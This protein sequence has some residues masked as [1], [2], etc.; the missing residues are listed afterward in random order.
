[1]IIKEF[2]VILPL[3]VDEYRIGQLYTVAEASKNQTGGGEGVE[4]VVNE[5]FNERSHPLVGNSTY[6]TGQYTLK[7]YHLE[8]KI[9]GFVRAVMPKGS[10]VLQEDAWNAFPYCKTV[11]TNPGYMKENM[12]I[13]IETM[14]KNDN[15]TT[16]NI[17]RLPDAEW[18]TVE[19]IKIDI[20]NDDIDKKDYK[21]AEDPKKFYSEKTKRGKLTKTWI[22]NA[23]PVMTC[24]KLV[25]AKFSFKLISSIVE[26]MIINGERR[27]FTLF[28]R[29][30]FCTID[31]WIE[32]TIED[33]RK[34]EEDT[35][36]KLDEARQNDQAK[37]S[38]L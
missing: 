18:K 13:S 24:Y 4:I 25:K 31:S 23:N 16:E 28:H 6:K 10:M 22:D 32:L 21:E 15:G 29:Q 20:A 27:I 2:R 3:T 12:E 26:K 7:M 1:M 37:G 38:G 30:L 17:H 9:P 36:K 5:A 11:L 33:I 35:K 14:H 8:S 19:V 34:I